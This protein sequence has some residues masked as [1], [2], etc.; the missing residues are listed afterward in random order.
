M[1]VFAVIVLYNDFDGHCSSNCGHL[2]Y[3]MD[4]PSVLT[5]V[6]VVA[7][8]QAAMCKECFIEKF[9]EH[10]KLDINY[11]TLEIRKLFSA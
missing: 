9:Y 4:G 5:V 2:L 8:E 1:N 6:F 10:D 3:F 11:F 7:H